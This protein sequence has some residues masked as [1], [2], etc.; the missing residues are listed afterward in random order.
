MMTCLY[1][2]RSPDQK[3]VLLHAPFKAP[4]L[5]VGELARLQKLNMKRAKILTVIPHPGN[6]STAYSTQS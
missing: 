3:A 4:T 1:N 2:D 6:P 5:F